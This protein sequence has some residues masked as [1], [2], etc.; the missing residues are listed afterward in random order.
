MMMSMMIHTNLERREG[1]TKKSYDRHEMV[2]SMGGTLGLI[3]GFSFTDIT[4]CLIDDF[5]V[6]T[7]T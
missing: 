2:A 4:S 5:S 1:G 7:Y 6:K 3:I